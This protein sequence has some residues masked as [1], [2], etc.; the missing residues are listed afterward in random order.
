MWT[1]EL[2]DYVFRFVLVDAISTTVRGTEEHSIRTNF[3][4]S[5]YQLNGF[6]DNKHPNHW[7]ADN[8]TLLGV[9]SGGLFLAHFR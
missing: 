5:F 7:V 3:V 2:R 1:F 8:R 6:L 9:L 4:E